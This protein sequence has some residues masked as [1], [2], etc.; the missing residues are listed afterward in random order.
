MSIR[1]ALKPL[2]GTGRRGNVER[3]DYLIERF[4]V[5]YQFGG[6]WKCGCADFAASD[7]CRH[8]REAAGR[9]AAQLGI[10]EHF[11]R[12]STVLGV[13]RMGHDDAAA[14]RGSLQEIRGSGS[15]RS[16]SFLTTS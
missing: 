16:V 1:A 2:D 7:A 15:S 12:G 9:R 10:I 13:N 3:S 5:G 14:R 11:K 8:T 6:G 4:R